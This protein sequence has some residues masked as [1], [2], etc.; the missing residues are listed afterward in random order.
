MSAPMLLVLSAVT[1]DETVWSAG[2]GTLSEQI[3]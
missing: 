2:P 3:A 1:H